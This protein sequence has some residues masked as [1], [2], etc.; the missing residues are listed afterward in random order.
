MPIAERTIAQLID[1][2]DGSDITDGG[3]ERVDFAVPGVSYHIDLS[4]ANAAKFDKALAPFI[5]AAVKA[6]R[7]PLS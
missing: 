6:N 1:D 2:L 4:A 3:G 7:A 5:A